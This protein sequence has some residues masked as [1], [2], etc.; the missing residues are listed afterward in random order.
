MSTLSE[1]SE[2]EAEELIRRL[3]PKLDLSEYRE[4]LQAVTP[5]KWYK[6][7]LEEGEE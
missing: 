2:E 5:G 3:H 4:K 1:L 6:V 7:T